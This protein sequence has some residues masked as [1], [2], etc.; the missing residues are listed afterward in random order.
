[1]EKVETHSDDEKEKS[2]EIKKTK[3]HGEIEG[4]FGVDRS[5]GRGKLRKVRTRWWVQRVKEAN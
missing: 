1:V 5:Q 2:N 4:G 3:Y